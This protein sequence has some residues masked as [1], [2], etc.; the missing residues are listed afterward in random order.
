L[1]LASH[2]KEGVRG[3]NGLVCGKDLVGELQDEDALFRGRVV[4]E[5]VRLPRMV[6]RRLLGEGEGHRGTAEAQI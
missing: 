1:H 4:S 5:F 6:A 2:E 3:R